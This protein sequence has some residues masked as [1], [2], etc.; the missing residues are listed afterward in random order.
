MNSDLLTRPRVDRSNQAAT[1][2]ARPSVASWLSAQDRRVLGLWALAHIALLVLGW[3]AA[4]T[5][6]TSKAH[7]PL[8]DYQNWD[9]VHYVNI[10][11]HGYFGPRAGKTDAA[12]FPGYPVALAMTHAVIPNWTA[13]ELVLSAVAG[14]VALVA[15]GR[16]AGDSQAALYLLC[17]PAAVFLA[18][19]YSESL[20]LALA[21]PAWS[22]ARRRNWTAAAALALGAAFV[23]VD[24][25]FLV[26]ALGV[27][28]L[29]TERGVRS[30]V[31]ALA[32][33]ATAATAPVDYFAYLHRH[34]GRW[35]TW[36]DVNQK[37]WDLH[38]V[39]FVTSFKNSYLG[40][41]GH[42]YG[43]EFGYMEQLEIGCLFVIALAAIAQAATRRWAEAVYCGLA[44]VALGTSTWYQSV[45]RTLLVMFPIWVGLAQTSARWPVVGRAYLWAS[46]PIAGVTALMFLSGRWA[47]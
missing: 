31:H 24:G 27:M 39:G 28:A 10:A 30:R 35:S 7:L 34:S 45:P 16:L 3:A 18:V 4:W 6:S 11:E 9:T 25:L 38:Y 17:A 37:G 14:G 36:W 47:G 44:A 29:T 5:Q 26:P 41:F 40:A 43:A 13:A 32:W 19:G 20:F 23:R 1:R 46:S 21:V 42:P 15:L 33:L 8:L 12:F 2:R 22:A